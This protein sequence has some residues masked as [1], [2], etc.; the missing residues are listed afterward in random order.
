M[1]E[2]K[3]TTFVQTNNWAG[4]K[5]TIIRDTV[6]GSL[7]IVY[8]KNGQW[9][10]YTLRDAAGT[11]SG[12]IVISELAIII[13]NPSTPATMR[14]TINSDSGNTQITRLSDVLGTSVYEEY[15]DADG[16]GYLFKARSLC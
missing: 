3:D 2:R 14:F 13:P 6:P 12:G 10:A 16:D 5:V 8:M 9:K 7:K 1:T 11:I 4:A 15:S